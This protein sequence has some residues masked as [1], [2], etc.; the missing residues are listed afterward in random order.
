MLLLNRFQS[1]KCLTLFHYCILQKSCKKI[2]IAAVMLAAFLLYH[3]H[4]VEN[5]IRFIIQDFAATTEVH[6]SSRQPLPSQLIKTQI[7]LRGGRLPQEGKWVSLAGF[8]L[9]SRQGLHWESKLACLFQDL[10]LE[11]QICLGRKGILQPVLS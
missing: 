4:F 3:R 7:F 5:C 6:S 1:Q 9:I 2:K 10:Q 8:C 11:I